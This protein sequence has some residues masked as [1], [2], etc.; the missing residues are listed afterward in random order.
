MKYEE[1]TVKELR[2]ESKLRGL[3]L[4]SKGKKFTKPEL[5]ERLVKYDAEAGQDWIETLET[6]G[7]VAEAIPVENVETK[8]EAE[9]KEEKTEQPV[10]YIK[11]AR[12][13]K[14]IIEKYSGRKKQNVY[15]NELK[16]GSLVV[17]VHYVEAKDG[18]IYKKLRTAKV[19][20]VNR[21][22]EI[23]RVQLL[24]GEEKELLFED[25]LY[26]RNANP[27]SSYPRDIKDYLR[28]KRTEKGKAIISE[29]FSKTDGTN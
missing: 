1:M 29:R 19:I 14:E 16:V 25:L 24:L 18:E 20:G 7:E 22:K 2:A 13:F 6:E 5:I 11:Y 9:V 4:E 27:E 10:G 28:N 3:T 21:K 8:T 12:N 15:D 23:V 26:I 17:F